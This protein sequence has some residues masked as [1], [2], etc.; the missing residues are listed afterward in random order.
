MLEA[1][2]V[3]LEAEIPTGQQDLP[4]AGHLHQCCHS[5]AV[6]PGGTTWV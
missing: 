3:S 6:L 5:K 2:A 1:A 4:R